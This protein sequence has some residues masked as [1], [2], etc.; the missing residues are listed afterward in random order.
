MA[1]T[2]LMLSGKLNFK[3]K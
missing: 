1:L 3:T 2:A